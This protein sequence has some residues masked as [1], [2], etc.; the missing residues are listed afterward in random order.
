MADINLNK[1]GKPDFKVAGLEIWVHGREFP[2]SENYW[3]V[4]WLIVTAHCSRGNSSV[5]VT[6]SILHVPEFKLLLD[7]LAAFMP[8]LKGKVELPTM[9][10][11]LKVEFEAEPPIPNSAGDQVVMRVKLTP[12]KLF[13]NH[14]FVF[15]IKKADLEAG[16]AQL[17][18][19]LEKYP[20]K[21]D[22]RADF[23]PPA[24]TAG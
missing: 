2:E 21:G 15:D 10:P 7:G 12:D 14:A 19:I 22:P 4:N 18:S 9:E 23:T 13:E 11:Y 20:V 16:M 6:G 24:T 8:E 5:W 3:D 1:L 17:K